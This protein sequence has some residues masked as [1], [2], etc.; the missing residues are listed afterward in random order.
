VPLPSSDITVVIAGNERP[1]SVGTTAADLFAEEKAALVARVNGELRDLAHVLADGDVVEPVGPDSDEG[2]AVLRHSA[3]HV[4]AQAVQQINPKARLGIGPPIRDGFYYDFD[5]EDPFTPEDL[6]ALEKVMQRIINE[7]QT[8]VRRVVTDE[9]AREELSSEPYK[10]ELIGLK[11]GAAQAVTSV[12]G[13]SVE[14]GAGELTI[15]DNIRR[16]GS[17]AWGDLCRGPHVPTTKVLGNAFK[18]MRSAAAYWRGSEKNPQ[19]QRVYGTAW[20]SKQAL[21]AFLARLAEAE[22]RDHR[23]LGAEL[24]LFSFPEEIGSGLA[25]FHPKGGIIRREMEDYSRRRHEEAGYEF[26]YSPH[27]TKGSLFQT[28][29]HLDWYAESMYPPMHLDEERDGEG[30]IRKQGQDYYLKPMNCPFHCLIFRAR[31]RSYRELPLRLFEFGSVY[32]YEKSGVVHGLTRVR[33]M[34]QD[35][36]HIYVTSEQLQSELKTLLTFVIDLLKDYGLD[37]FYLEL[38]TRNEEK[39]VGTDENWAKATEALREAATDSGLD[40]VADPGGAAFY[41][42]KISVQCRDAIGRTWQMSTIQVDFN[43]P[44]RFELEYQSPD[45]SRQRPVM[46]HRALF[47][48]VE[49]FFGVLT[50]HYA[51]AFPPWLAPVQV[52]GIPVAEEFNDYLFDIADQLKAK[53]IRV[54]VDTSDDRFP[55][56]IRTA[57]KS[58]VPFMLIAGEDDRSA[59]AVSFRYRDGSQKNGV[60]IADAITEIV[61]AVESRRQV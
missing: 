2:L 6:K 12:D 26:V 59:G 55:K 57:Q 14:V 48:S 21:G 16:D 22:K 39:Y 56:K 13:A 60:P 61:E 34:T 17:R 1:V 29:G 19:L 54:E 31:G 44:E 28:S 35:D 49:R 47:G 42:P 51:G 45:G 33:G 9:A 30:K 11:G 18:L 52:I 4:L 23:R 46:I 32:R 15:Y 27:I 24:D 50:E 37:D 38:S 58:K 7:S 20:P 5:V 3:A 8:F 40:F 41:G 43:L 25:V 53:R 36:A 10:C